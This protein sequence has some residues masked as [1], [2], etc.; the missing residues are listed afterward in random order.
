[1][2]QDIIKKKSLEHLNIV[3]GILVSRAGETLGYTIRNLLKWCDW[4]LIVLDNE[5]INTLR[6][7]NEYLKQFP[8]RIK[9]INSGFKR[10]DPELENVPG[11]LL[12]RFKGL[13]GPIRETVFA[14]MRKVHKKKKIDLLIYPDSD[15][16]FTSHFEKLLLDFWSMMDKRVIKMRCVWPFGDFNTIGETK[17]CSHVRVFKFI[18]EISTYPW[19]NDWLRHPSPFTSKDHLRNENILVHLS[20]LKDSMIEWRAKNWRSYPSLSIPLWTLENNVLDL[21]SEDIKN[22]LTKAP[23]LTVG[24]YLKKHGKNF[25]N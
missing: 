25:N 19:K 8:E 24:E 14:Y 5:D 17:M 18:P 11:S 12:Q 22:K 7:V 13:Q 4:I 23:D 20:H 21:K 6:V 16:I 9:V 3:G 1:M 2:T 10:I 15:E